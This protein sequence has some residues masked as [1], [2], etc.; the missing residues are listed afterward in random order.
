[1]RYHFTAPRIAIV[2]K[3]VGIDKDVKKLE[4]SYIA[5]RNVNGVATLENSFSVPKKVKRGYHITQQF[6]Y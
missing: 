4:Y 5:N 1:M 3:R 6:H 2:I